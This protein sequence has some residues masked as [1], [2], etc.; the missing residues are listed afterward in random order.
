MNKVPSIGEEST[1]PVHRRASVRRG[2]ALAGG[3]AGGAG[4]V[5]HWRKRRLRRPGS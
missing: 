1:K 4:P 5:R 3:V 2:T